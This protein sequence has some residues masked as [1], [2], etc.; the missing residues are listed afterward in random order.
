MFMQE[1]L[2]KHKLQ[3]ILEVMSPDEVLSVTQIQYRLGAVAGLSLSREEIE[4]HL[5]WGRV[6]PQV[7]GEPFRPTQ[8]NVDRRNQGVG[9][10]RGWTLVPLE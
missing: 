5:T 10:F 3:S 2:R 7:S 1:D 4:A 6:Q 9:Y 8:R